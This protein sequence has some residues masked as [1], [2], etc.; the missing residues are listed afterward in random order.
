MLKQYT[1]YMQKPLNLNRVGSWLHFVVAA[2]VALSLLGCRSEPQRETVRTEYIEVRVPVER[3]L[4][5]I[6]LNDDIVSEVGGIENTLDLQFYISKT[7]TLS[8]VEGQSASRIEDGQMVR[9]GSTTRSNVTIT[10]YTPGVLYSYNMSGSAALLGNRLNIAFEEYAG[11]PVISFARQGNGWR[12]ELL[13]A[14]RARSTINYGGMDYTVSF[15]GSDDPPY[16]MITIQESN[17]ESGSSRRVTGL[18]L[19]R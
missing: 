19:E 17:T 3:T 2:A 18:T 11:N 5:M 4:V 7:I 9:R 13:Y 8:L 14:D 12:Y 16:L 15:T 6:P 10:A 1:I